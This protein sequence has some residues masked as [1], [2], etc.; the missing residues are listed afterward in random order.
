MCVLFFSLIEMESYKKLLST[1]F[2]FLTDL[3]KLRSRGRSRDR[4]Y[5]GTPMVF[6]WL[7]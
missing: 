6:F 2:A 1:G 3:S 7:G 5:G 4:A